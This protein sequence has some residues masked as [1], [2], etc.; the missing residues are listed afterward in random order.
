MSTR[1]ILAARVAGAL[2]TGAGAFLTIGHAGSG[3]WYALGVFCG[4][5]TMA[6]IWSV[7]SL[8][9]RAGGKERG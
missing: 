8:A 1:L 3:Q 9:L 2:A 5:A 4:A 7:A 6:A